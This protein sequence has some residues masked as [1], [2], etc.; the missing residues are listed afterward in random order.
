MTRTRTRDEWQSADQLQHS[1]DLI[2]DLEARV[3]DPDAPPSRKKA[4]TTRGVSKLHQ[5][6]YELSKLVCVQGGKGMKNDQKGQAFMIWLFGLT[7]IREEER[8]WIHDTHKALKPIVGNRYFVNHSNCKLVYALV[9]TY[10]AFLEY[11]QTTKTPQKLNRL[12]SSVKAGLK[13]TK[14]IAMIRAAAILATQ[15]ELPT[16][17]A[18]KKMGYLKLQKLTITLPSS[19]ASNCGQPK[20]EQINSLRYPA[21]YWDLSTKLLW[22]ILT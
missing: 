16:I 6:M 1:A 22:K 13:D 9:P 10:L 3:K 14:V 18:S 8:N 5:L 7:G 21:L 17:Y 19:S 11:L 4:T 2:K 12:E 20:M 15:I